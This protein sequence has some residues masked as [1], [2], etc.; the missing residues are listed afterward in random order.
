L[1]QLGDHA[2][3]AATITSLRAKRF[4]LYGLGQEIRWYPVTISSDETSV[5]YGGDKPA[6]ASEKPDESI[7]FIRRHRRPGITQHG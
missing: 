3:R 6:V 7:Y 4:I 5:G 1:K 2:A